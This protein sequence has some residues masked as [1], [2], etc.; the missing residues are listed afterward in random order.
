MAELAYR[1]LN[2]FTV[3]GARL[4]GNPLAVFEDGRGLDDRTMQALALQ[5]NLSET[6]FVLPATSGEAAARV[7]IFTPTIEMPFAWHPT[8]GTAH[9]VRDRFG[10][11]DRFSLEMKVGLVEVAARG[12]RFTLRAAVAPKVRV[13]TA[14]PAAVARML[15]L[16]PGALAGPPRWV[17]VGSEQLV[18]PVNDAAD[19][20]R[21]RPD[22]ALFARDGFSEKSGE[23]MAY[24]VAER[25]DEVTARFF[26]MAHGSVI[27]DPATGSAC[28]NL[29]G[30]LL[31]AGRT[32]P[33]EKTVSQGAAIG[34]P[35]RLELR[36][37]ARR[38]IFVSG[39]VIELGRGTVV[40]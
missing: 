39:E 30:Y 22:P 20:A 26:F 4:S 9:V 10:A 17:D 13:P 3:A 24:V 31:D 35:S 29:G 6:T 23:S 18:V 21:A 8:L 16:E 1:L 5:L 34:R 7:R 33:F 37:D 25:G 19:V 11:G 15:G 14:E 32:P 40:L 2:V 12:D 28:T 36:V 38:D 27:E